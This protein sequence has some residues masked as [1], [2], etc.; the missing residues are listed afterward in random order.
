MKEKGIAIVVCVIAAAVVVYAIVYAS[1]RLQQARSEQQAIGAPQLREEQ[2]ICAEQQL[3]QDKE[4]AEL[5]REETR[6]ADDYY[7]KMAQDR[8]EIKR[9]EALRPPS[10]AISVL[11]K[12]K[13]HQ[14]HGSWIV[15]VDLWLGMSIGEVYEI[16][17]WPESFNDTIGSYGEH[18]QWVYEYD[19]YLY[20][21][22]DILTSVQK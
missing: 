6:V 16:M 7:N 17:G 21:E 8:R 4:Q 22:N 13:P 9:L 11:T 15:R 12:I 2:R 1:T 18:S 5:W 10:G 20:F 19:V 14:A 3:I